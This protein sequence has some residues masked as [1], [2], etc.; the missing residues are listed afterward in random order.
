MKRIAAVILGL[1]APLFSSFSET[2][3][4]TVPFG[5]SESD[6]SYSISFS[7]GGQDTA[8]PRFSGTLNAKVA[9]DRE[10]LEVTECT[11]L[12]GSRIY[13]ENFSLQTQS[14]V[15]Y[16]GLGTFPTRFSF[17]FEGIST[18]VMTIGD[19]GRVDPASGKLY[20]GDIAA[21]SDQGVG[22][23]TIGVGDVQETET[24][25]YAVEPSEQ[26]IVS[27]PTIVVER[28]K[29]D[30]Y[31]QHFNFTLTFSFDEEESD[32]IEGSNSSFTLRES[33]QL[34]ATYSHSETT[35]FGS[36]YSFNKWSFDGDELDSENEAG[37][38]LYLAYA[39]GFMAYRDDQQVPLVLRYE[40]GNPVLRIPSDYRNDD[41]YVEYSRT[42][43]QDSWSMVPEAWLAGGYS[44]LKKE[45]SGEI[46][47][48]LPVVDPPTFIRLRAEP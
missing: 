31:G 17:L 10:T 38:P 43:Q 20:D 28:V 36:W 11:F 42:L 29:D 2:L 25:D 16:E 33:G 23:I 18:R 41:V 19:T 4:Y 3:R 27:S 37:V 47:L 21:I 26:E 44:S 7:T 8:S 30:L 24:I 12:D 48:T 39:L 14:D 32:T 46:V 1:L 34:T 40:H 22:S 15:T 45:S 13:W 5:I 35:P 9:F 6:I